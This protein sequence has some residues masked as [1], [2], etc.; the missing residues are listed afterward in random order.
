MTIYTRTANRR[1]PSQDRKGIWEEQIV[2]RYR[3]ITARTLLLAWWCHSAGHISRRQLRIW[4]SAQ[5]MAERRRYAKGGKNTPRPMF[6]IDEI[7]SL[8]GGRGSQTADAELLADIRE[9]NRLGLVS[10][11]DHSIEFAASADD[12]TI[13][14]IEDFQ[15][16]QDQLPH[17][18]RTVPVPRRMLRALAA[19]LTRGMTAV[20]LATLIRSL[21]WSRA[22]GAFRV[23]GRT[24]RE[25]ISEVFG[26]A[27]RTVTDARTRLIELGWLVPIEAPQLMLNRYGAHDAIN[28]SWSDT[29]EESA[30]T[31][32]GSA[33]PEGQSRGGSARPTKHKTLPLTGNTNT[34]R[35][36]R[37]RA[38]PA[39]VCKDSIR[40]D[41]P[42][43]CI[44]GGES[45]RPST[46]RQRRVD[47][48][49][50]RSR[51]SARR[52]PPTI[53][54]I[55]SED[56]RDTG[57]LLELHRQASALGMI[58]ASEAGRLDFLSMAER[59]RARGRK[60]GALL[61]WLVSNR[62]SEFITHADEEQAAR[63]LREHM[64][65]PSPRASTENARRPEPAPFSE[66]ERF[67]A[68][69]LRVAQQHRIDDPYLVARQGREITR[70]EW[71]LAVEGFNEAQIN[72]WH[73]E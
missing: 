54:D 49:P 58:S 16:V 26:V 28:T 27:P 59:A 53:R 9:L 6:T 34:R 65:G 11:A 36:A 21:F 70:D 13:E 43:Q 50:V 48:G 62:K 4:F 23:D 71:D 5:E 57:R 72:R 8:V 40:N 41:I 12:L 25:W 64:N 45:S 38:G 7:K 39:G 73:P 44:S 29:P 30:R 47:R 33:S 10:I 3:G 52:E 20:V 32:G 24:K 1:H 15:Q 68:A 55:R 46:C 66:D 17:P 42:K 31:P 63:R 14:R 69:C 56:I 19:G 22:E 67:V 60:A 2:G 51:S 18:Q 37:S 35:P 61:Y